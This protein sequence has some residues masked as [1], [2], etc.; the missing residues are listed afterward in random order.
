[1]K[2]YRLLLLVVIVLGLSSTIH[3]QEPP[4]P[5]Q[6]TNPPSE[7]P[8]TIPAEMPTEIPTTAPTDPPT[9]ATTVSPTDAPPVSPTETP[10]DVPGEIPTAEVTPSVTN[11][12]PVVNLDASSILEA[13]AGIP[14]TLQFSVSDDEDGLVRVDRAEDN[15]STAA[16]SIEHSAP[17]ETVPPFNTGITLTYTAPADFSG[18][19][20]LRL[21]AVDPG[22]LAVYFMLTVNVVTPQATL[23]PTAE[24]TAIPDQV[25]IINFDPAASEESIQAMLA[26]LGAVEISRIPQIGAMKVRIPLAVSDTASAL[27]AL[28]T[29][30][31]ARA[32]GVTNIEPE[33][34]YRLDAF[35]NDPYFPPSFP[36]TTN[37]Q[38]GLMNGMGSA[39]IYAPPAWNISVKD[40][41]GVTVA[42]LDTGIDATHPDLVGKLLPGWDFVN[43]DANTDDDNSHGTHVAGVIA[44]NTNNLK[45]IAGIAFNAKLLPVKVC[46]ADGGC[47]TYDIAAGLVFATDKGARVA[48]MSLG[49]STISTTVEGA[50]RYALSRNMTLVAAAGN[51]GPNFNGYQY[52]ASFDGVISVAAHDIN[53]AHPAFSTANNRVTVSAPGVDIVSTIPPE[54]DTCDG[55]PDGYA[56]FSRMGSGVCAAWSGTSM[57]TPHVTGIAALL[58]A[59]NIATTPPA[60][61]EALICGATDAGTPGYDNQFGYGQVKA[62]YALNWNLNS[63]NCKVTAP[64]DLFQN[65]APIA[66]VPFTNTQAI[67]S[68]S[69]STSDSDPDTGCNLPNQTV[70]YKFT[71]AFS[72]SYQITTLGST[73]NTDLNV[74]H[75][76]EEGYPFSNLVGCND[77]AFSFNNTSLLNVALTA[78]QTYYIM[79]GSIGTADDQILNLDV[80]RSLIANNVDTQENSPQ[81]AYYGSWVQQPMAGASLG[82][83]KST[84]DNSAFASFTFRGRYLELWR[85][86]GPTQGDL[87]LWVDGN[88][89]RIISDRAAVTKP[90]QPVDPFVGP[91]DVGSSGDPIGRWHYIVLRRA[92]AGPAGPVDIDRIQT[93]EVV[94]T[95]SLPTIPVTVFVDDS[96]GG[97]Q[98]CA[99]KRYCYELGTFT[100]E[101]TPG[102][103]LGKVT[104]TTSENAR[105][106]FRAT[107]TTITIFRNTGPNYGSMDIYV[108][109]VL[110][111]TANNSSNTPRVRVPYVISGLGAY[112]HVVQLVNKLNSVL[113]FDGA[114][115]SSPLPIPASTLQTNENSPSLVYS[116]YWANLP[117]PGAVGNTLRQSDGPEAAVS[118]KYTGNFFC[119]TYRNTPTAATVKVY[120]DGEFIQDITTGTAIIYATWCDPFL[121][122]DRTHDV[123]LEVMSG[124]FEL[125]AVAARRQIVITPSMGIV[126]ET[127]PAIFYDTAF[128]AWLNL[129][130]RSMGGYVFQGGAARSTTVD[131][132]RLKFYMNGT[133]FI[134][135]TSVDPINSGWEVYVDGVLRPVTLQGNPYPFIDLGY[136]E[137]AY[138]FRPFAYAITGLSPGIHAIELR[139]WNCF[140]YTLPG[141]SPPY[142]PRPCLTTDYVDFDGVRVFP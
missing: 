54:F 131:G 8:T 67:H 3:A 99:L 32:A 30:I 48:N 116:G 17:V 107:G 85:T 59:D 121:R 15:A 14:L 95:N 34:E 41:L 40:G 65:A 38:W 46:A 24:P 60:V 84:T 138:R 43:D 10:L 110:L 97:T 106:S 77:Q 88:L 123:R 124:T 28:S 86:V 102:A 114:Q 69:T 66:T 136:P 21:K 129:T 142:A 127:S 23:E 22:G 37:Q 79:V 133:G 75:M 119:I 91:M 78:G 12:P 73:Y 11:A 130:R 19:D 25:R 20:S 63:P 113:A 55:N 6:P 56:N 16:I 141:G 58:V 27:L 108:D 42:V 44:A 68:R 89:L 122:S 125:D 71:P 104:Q 101:N 111:R 51:T 139:K 13:T 33:F 47:S 76:P 94:G 53:G 7:T 128:G 103:T 83:V 45:G 115:A 26:A 105:I 4:Q 132:A 18:A 109:G 36:A 5:Q 74:W 29:D 92:V 52:P 134:L 100:V 57:A 96:L 39:S 87:E 62:D 35:P 82:Q 31:E 50:V 1:V 112:S 90:N 49:G 9:D 137:L 64:N 72:D 93:Y 117:T 135:Y 126:Q 81:I 61:R 80:R 70:W 140:V 98:P 118:F 2:F 120:E